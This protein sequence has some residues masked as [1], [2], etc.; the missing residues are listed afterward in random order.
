M[1]PSGES[2]ALR[3]AAVKLRE[4]QDQLRAAEVQLQTTRRGGWRTE[5]ARLGSACGDLAEFLEGMSDD[6]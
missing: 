5:A 3:S 1:T 2:V 6:A 4:A